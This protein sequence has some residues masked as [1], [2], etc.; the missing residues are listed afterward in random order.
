VQPLLVTAEAADAPIAAATTAAEALY[1]LH[2]S[3]WQRQL[4]N[5]NQT[6]CSD[7]YVRILPAMHVSELDV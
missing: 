1:A 7:A 3:D 2:L 6:Q 4:A 5:N